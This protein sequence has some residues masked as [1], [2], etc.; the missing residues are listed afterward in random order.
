MAAQ[1]RIAAPDAKNRT[2]LLDAAEELM[3]EKGY[4]AVTSRRIADKAG[5]KSQL[6]HYYFRTMDEL[7]LAMFRRRAEEGLK[8]QRELLDS[9][10]PLRGLWEFNTETSSSAFTMEIT[11]L[12][13][14]R[15][16]FRAEVRRY[17]ERFRAAQLEVVAAV[18]ERYKI[19]R[20]VCT[21]AALAM[22]MT[23]IGR[24][25]SMEE[26]LGFSLG[27]KETVEFMER[28]LDQLESYAKQE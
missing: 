16:E 1:R 28:Y 6:V 15:E 3:L 13:R 17:S 19:P 24:I 21:P 12:A 23:A 7:F 9:E 25:M 2:L 10:R 22:I 8:H 26:N 4:A 5:L 14:H 18:M 20:E 11:S 27:H